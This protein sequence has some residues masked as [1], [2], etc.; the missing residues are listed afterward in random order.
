MLV[1]VQRVGLAGERLTVVGVVKLPVLPGVD[2][3]VPHRLAELLPAKLLVGVPGEPDRD[4][5][6]IW[7]RI[8]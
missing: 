6:S 4:R 3:F 5:F 7:G 1:N 2:E 8:R